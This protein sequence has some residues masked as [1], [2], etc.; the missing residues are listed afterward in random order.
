[1]LKA[2]DRKGAVELITDFAYA[3]RSTSTSAG[4]RSATAPQQVRARIHGRQ[5][6]P[7]PEEWNEIVGF[8]VPKRERNRRSKFAP[9]KNEEARRPRRRRAVCIRVRMRWRGATS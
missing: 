9:A 7:Y 2:G 5:A 8:G 4:S 6:T 1:M 3:T